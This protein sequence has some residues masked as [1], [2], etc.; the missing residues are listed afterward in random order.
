VRAVGYRRLLLTRSDTYD[1]VVNGGQI[2]FYASA[3]TAIPVVLVIYVV[4]A[5]KALEVTLDRFVHL[6]EAR[7]SPLVA[8]L[9][10]ESTGRAVYR[11]TARIQLRQPRFSVSLKRAS[12]I[13]IMF[14]PSILFSATLLALMAPFLFLII[15]PVVGECFALHALASNRASADATAWAAIGLAATGVALLA[16]FFWVVLRPAVGVVMMPLSPLLLLLFG[17]VLFVK[18]RLRPAEP[19][20]GSD[21]GDPDPQEPSRS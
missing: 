11:L 15:S 5:R 6:L 1:R 7:I 12:L 17:P 10:F 19:E 2:A 18:R 20:A 8:K 3:A 13:L 9:F 14:V 4:G 16:P 21:A